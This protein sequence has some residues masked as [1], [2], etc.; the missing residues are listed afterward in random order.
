MIITD[1]LAQAL[2]RLRQR[3]G[4]RSPIADFPLDLFG[5]KDWEDLTEL[6]RSCILMLDSPENSA[7][8]LNAFGYFDDAAESTSVIERRRRYS[9]DTGMSMRTI[10][11]REEVAILQ[12]ADLI[13]TR[14]LEPN[15]LDLLTDIGKSIGEFGWVAERRGAPIAAEMKNLDAAALALWEAVEKWQG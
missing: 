7:V 14:L 8:L 13:N 15:L 6:V 4:Y 10:E 12:L 3:G 9:Q 5:A 11:R 1:A 2:K